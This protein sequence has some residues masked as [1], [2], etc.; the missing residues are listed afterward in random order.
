MRNVIIALCLGLLLTGPVAGTILTA[1]EPVDA[2]ADC[3]IAT[4]LDDLLSLVDWE[5]W[6]MLDGI[7]WDDWLLLDGIDWDDWLLD[8]G[9]D[10]SEFDA[11]LEDILDDG[12]STPG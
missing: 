2:R 11:W 5:S 9:I 12:G 8:A 3:A 10:R 7:D 4:T 1:D 6:L